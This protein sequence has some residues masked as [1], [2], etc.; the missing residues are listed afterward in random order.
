V[1]RFLRTLVLVIVF[2]TAAARADFTFIHCSD[3]HVGAGEN[4]HRRKTFTG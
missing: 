1:K 4:R 2:T 3:I